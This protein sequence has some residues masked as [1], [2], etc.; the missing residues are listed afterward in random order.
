MERAPACGRS[1][2]SRTRPLTCRLRAPYDNHRVGK[3]SQGVHPHA[4]RPRR[5][6]ASTA[7]RPIVG[8]ALRRRLFSIDTR[9]LAALRI[10]LGALL[11]VDLAQRARYLDVG[12]TDAGVLPRA[13]LGQTWSLH[14]LGGGIAIEAALF[15]VAAVAA[16]MLVAG[17]RT[18]L[19]TVVS[20]ILLVSL[21]NRSWPFEDG[22]DALL[23]MLLFWSMFLPLGACWSADAARRRGPTAGVGAVC[24]AATAALMLQ[25]VFVYALGGLMKTGA[26]WHATG[27]AV[28]RALE[29]THWSRPFGRALLNFPGP[30]RMASF[31]VPWFEAAGA[32]AMFVPVAT[33]AVRLVTI[34][35]F[36]VFQLGLGL[37]IQLN[38]FP[39]ISS[40]ATLPFLPSVFWDRVTRRVRSTGPV[41]TRPSGWIG[42]AV[43]AAVLGY[44][45]AASLST[46]GAFAL[47]PGLRDTAE[48][49]GII[50]G[51][52]MYAPH[53]AQ[54]DLRFQLV[55]ER[56]GGS[57]ADLLAD[58]PDRVRVLHETRRFKYFLEWTVRG[59]NQARLRRSY[60]EW[61]CHTLAPVEK[62][63]L[64]IAVRELPDG[65]WRSTLLFGEDCRTGK[66][67]STVPSAQG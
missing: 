43:V 67:T 28:A 36:A 25:F 39:W 4:G 40:A 26:D 30:L 32:V 29:Q 62:T 55:G 10:A 44:S 49:L 65:P 47:P 64:F 12:Y 63:Y 57:T 34:A 42:E 37:S 24:S 16:V 52:T 53:S 23:A 13:T 50:Q 6:A 60:L 9:S 31:A 22:G 48:A 11:L 46:L 56:A 3:P 5:S 15:A 58:A 21:H 1:G 14:A 35:A 38:L 51:W 66:P 8:S 7:I 41:V 27:T 59:D 2:S 33:A 17:W 19:A 20:W 54:V 18:R 45:I 61:A